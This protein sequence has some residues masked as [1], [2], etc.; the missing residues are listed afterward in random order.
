M[1]QTEPPHHPT[2]PQTRKRNFKA[3]NPSGNVVRMAV[4]ARKRSGP[5]NFSTVGMQSPQQHHQELHPLH[6]QVRHGGLLGGGAQHVPT[7]S[8][9][10][11][12]PR[13]IAGTHNWQQNMSTNQGN[14]TIQNF[15]PNT[16]QHP[17]LNQQN[18]SSLIREVDIHTMPNEER[19]MRS[20]AMPVRQSGEQQ[21]ESN[22]GNNA[23]N[24]KKMKIQGNVSSQS[25]ATQVF[26]DPANIARPR[27]IAEALHPPKTLLMAFFNGNV[28]IRDVNGNT[29]L[30]VGAAAR[31]LEH[32]Q[33]YLS[34]GAD[35]LARN[36]ASQTPMGL[37]H[38][39]LPVNNHGQRL[40]DQRD[41]VISDVLKR[42][43]QQAEANRITAMIQQAYLGNIFNRHLVDNYAGPNDLTKV[44]K[45]CGGLDHRLQGAPDVDPRQQK[46]KK[47][48]L[49]DKL[50]RQG[51]TI[52]PPWLN[53]TYKNIEESKKNESKD[54]VKVGVEN[55]T[56]R[57]KQ[58]VKNAAEKV[59][60]CAGDTTTCEHSSKEDT[61]IQ[62]QKNSTTDNHAVTTTASHKQFDKK[63]MQQNNRDNASTNTRIPPGR[64]S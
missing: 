16:W 62:G 55:D 17:Q 37:F 20:S 64:R 42:A 19:G 61:A 33:Y 53:K 1:I 22:N 47:E 5:G 9:N 51:V 56:E 44:M 14:A 6:P 58:E 21:S 13:P 35:P 54:I 3:A 50:V 28:M 49:A 43:V 34:L 46:S 39:Q 59:A 11:S 26:Q 23:Y 12:P 18:T 57:S 32:V 24:S 31:S 10:Q 7:M 2:M 15:S 36:N 27:T 41:N 52:V 4:N 45:W 40:H 8:L 60:R 38:A 30:H 48:F 29:A 25:N 63:Q